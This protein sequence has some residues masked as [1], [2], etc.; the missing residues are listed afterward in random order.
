MLAE[1]EG[2]GAVV[3]DNYT[4]PSCQKAVFHW[5]V[6]AGDLGSASL[7]AYLHKTGDDESVPLVNEFGMDLPASGLSGSVL[8]PL[9]SG[10]YYFSTENTDQQWAI[11]VECQ[12][13]V[14]PVGTAIDLQAAGNIVTD[15]Y[16]LPACRK[17]VFVWSAQPDDSGAA[18]LI[19]RLCG[20]ECTT[21]VNEFQMDSND[22]LAGEALQPLDGGLYY[23]VS[24]NSN[25]RP[26]SVRWECRD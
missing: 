6:A 11:R 20:S 16:E 19:L 15:N 25:L 7:I 1:V 17:S 8:Q 5:R 4:W 3:T 23:F 13:N 14:A 12:D 21:L 2:E 22:L 24:E 10:G 9:A 26:W 18:S